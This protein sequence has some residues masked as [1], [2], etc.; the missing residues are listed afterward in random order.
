MQATLNLKYDVLSLSDVFEKFKN[1]SLKYYG[2]YP[3]HYLSATVLSWDAM[4]N[5]TKNNVEIISNTCMYL[6]SEKG[7]R[8]GGFLTSLRDIVKATMFLTFLVDI[9][10]STISILSVMTQ[11]KN[12]RILHI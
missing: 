8:G 9:I 1:G 4:L 7:V 12:Q 10:K 2:L 11:N 3:S 6:F 5:M